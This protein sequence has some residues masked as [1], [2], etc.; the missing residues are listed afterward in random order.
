M[1]KVLFEHSIKH[2]VVFEEYSRLILPVGW[3]SP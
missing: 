2:G 3:D 1:V